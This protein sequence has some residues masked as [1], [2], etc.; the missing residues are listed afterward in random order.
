MSLVNGNYVSEKKANGSPG[1]D[2][3]ERGGGTPRERI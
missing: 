2:D 1:L 3:D